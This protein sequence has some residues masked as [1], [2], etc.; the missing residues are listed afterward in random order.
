MLYCG[1]DVAGLLQPSS[2]DGP[3]LVVGL[4]LYCL[5][6]WT[7]QRP[8]LASQILPFWEDRPALDCCGGYDRHHG[9]ESGPLRG[10]CDGDHGLCQ[11]CGDYRAYYGGAT[12]PE[13]GSYYGDFDYFHGGASCCCFRHRRGFD[14]SGCRHLDVGDF[15]PDPNPSH[16]WKIGRGDLCHHDDCDESFYSLHRHCHRHR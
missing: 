13:I 6:Y 10:S 4:N 8:F 15:V 7:V 12:L 9:A 16:T 5:W 11:W 2:F 14:A 3:N 1:P